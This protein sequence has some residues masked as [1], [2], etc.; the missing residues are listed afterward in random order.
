M[1]FDVSRG[2]GDRDLGGQKH[3][4]SMD[5]ANS[6]MDSRRSGRG[7]RLESRCAALRQHLTYYMQPLLHHSAG[8]WNS[9]VDGPRRGLSKITALQ[10]RQPLKRTDIHLGT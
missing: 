5:D 6:T 10:E 9:G 1:R 3:E 2:F 4:I 8:S 7:F